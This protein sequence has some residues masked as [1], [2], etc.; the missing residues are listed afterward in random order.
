LLL[1][2]ML[3]CAHW[4]LRD[5]TPESRMLTAARVLGPLVMAGVFW[6]ITLGTLVSAGPVPGDDPNAAQVE[7]ERPR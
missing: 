7:A 2:P 6:A 5:G 3:A 4:H 1:L